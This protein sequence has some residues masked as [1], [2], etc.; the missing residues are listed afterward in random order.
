MSLQWLDIRCCKFTNFCKLY[1]FAAE[2]FSG[3]H[4]SFC[5]GYAGLKYICL[6][7]YR[8]FVEVYLI[9]LTNCRRAA[10]H[11]ASVLLVTYHHITSRRVDGCRPPYPTNN[12]TYIKSIITHSQWWV[13]CGCACGRDT[14]TK[15]S[16]AVTLNLY[17]TINWPSRLHCTHSP[18]NEAAGDVWQTDNAHYTTLWSHYTVSC[19]LS[20][21]CCSWY[22]LT[23]T[24][25]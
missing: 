7:I 6:R 23:V 12:L 16:P 24:N 9:Y 1:F 17:L 25:V 20:W 8:W 3:R 11:S 14:I 22:S 2:I 5:V 10:C 18:V 13:K 19:C 21:D 4:S 15:T